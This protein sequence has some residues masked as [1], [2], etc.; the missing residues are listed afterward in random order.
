MAISVCIASGLTM[1]AEYIQ[2]VPSGLCY[3]R[4]SIPTDVRH[5]Y[6]RTQTCVR[7]SLGT[8]DKAVAIHKAT[9]MNRD[10]ERIWSVMR[11]KDASPHTVTIEGKAILDRHGV[12]PASADQYRR[13][14]IGNGDHDVLFVPNE[15]ESYLD[16]KYISVPFDRWER[17]DREAF[18]LWTGEKPWEPEKLTREFLLSEAVEQ[19]MDYTWRP[20]NRKGRQRPRLAL[21]YVVEVC[22]DKLLSQYTRSDANK[23]RDYLLNKPAR[24][25]KGRPL[26]T[27]AVARLLTPIR[28]TF[29]H[30]I[31]EHGLKI[32]NHFKGVLIKDRGKDAEERPPFA[33]DELKRLVPLCQEMDDERRH[34]IG[35]LMDTG[36]RLADASTLM[37]RDVH[38][39]A[40]VPYIAI[41]LND[42]RKDPL[43]SKATIRDVPLV[44]MALWAIKRRREQC[45]KDAKY[46]FPT[47]AQDDV[48]KSDSASGA[49]NKWVQKAL[50][51]DKV[52]Y[53]FRHA[54]KDRIQNTGAPEYIYRHVQ[55]WTDGVGSAAGY[56]KG[57]SLNTL[58]E[59]MSKVVLAMGETKLL[60]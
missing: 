44:G 51:T 31:K 38:L 2:Q 18:E 30:M 17:K 36:C 26:K 13:T 47:Y 11:A 50:N 56:G 21:R 33:E 19:Y 49:L 6:K 52:L 20:E 43:K 25:K 22:G 1:V 58:H 7:R 57:P 16:E 15:F 42:A 27:D 29:T 12:A 60:L 32:E 46:V 28:S 14:E 23:V 59:W 3:Y 10:Q 35:V 40:P 55:G 4:R 39:D 5:H 37:W 9:A 24:G 54:M 8:H 41:R 48:N 45:P 53:C 34:L